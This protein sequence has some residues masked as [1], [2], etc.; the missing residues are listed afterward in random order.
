MLLTSQ[1]FEMT[2]SHDNYPSHLELVIIIY[3]TFLHRI[4]SRNSPPS[5]LYEL[6]LNN[7]PTVFI[8]FIQ[9]R[10][11]MITFGGVA[12]IGKQSLI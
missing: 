9:Y 8:H 12:G 10:T 4:S 1:E 2:L 5:S 7:D 11:E 6:S 3:V